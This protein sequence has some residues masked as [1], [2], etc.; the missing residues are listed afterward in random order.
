ML[1]N[2]EETTEKTQFENNYVFNNLPI[3]EFN[4]IIDTLNKTTLIINN[5]NIIKKKGD[6]EKLDFLI[7]NLE[8][9]YFLFNDISRRCLIDSYGQ[10][11]K[12]F[13]EIKKNKKLLK[14]K[15]NSHV[16][17]KR[18]ANDF[19]ISFMNLEPE[20]NMV[21][22]ADILRSFS[23]FIKEEKGKKNK[24]IFVYKE[25]NQIDNKSFK[26]IGKMKE[27][28]DNIQ[29]EAFKKDTTLIIPEIL[30]YNNLF[31]YIKYLFKE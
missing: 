7:K 16:N 21:S 6:L 24:D 13:L 1:Q 19:T 28:F 8:K 26:I 29:K 31:T 17:K 14:N 3:E 12:N 10:N 30:T 5:K 2:Q 25:N 23:N 22:T 27:L 4:N 15:D 9:S 20:N 18:I 11:K